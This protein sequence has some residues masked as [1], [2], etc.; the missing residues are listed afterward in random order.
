MQVQVLASTVT[1][2]FFYLLH[3]AGDALLVDPVDAAVAIT[4][5]REL[6]PERL[7]IFITHGHPDHIGGNE[8]VVAALGCEVIAPARAEHW[9]VAH[10]TGVGEGSRLELGGT[11]FTIHETPG[12]TDDHLIAVGDEVVIGGDLWF[13]GGCGH[14]RAGGDLPS[15]FRTFRRTA[16]LPGHLRILPGHHYAAQNLAFCADLFPHDEAITARLARARAWRRSDGPWLPTLESERAYN[17]FH[18]FNDA[19]VEAAL[20]TRY[21]EFLD[22]SQGDAE[23][24][25]FSALRRARDLFTPPVT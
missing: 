16:G 23:E 19:R 6:K 2:N 15:L 18:R 22:P 7:R 8:E 21:G 25:I 17:P 3:H 12:H 11:S 14:T 20:K 1:D 10:D 9:P 24:R 5:A 4:A 13:V